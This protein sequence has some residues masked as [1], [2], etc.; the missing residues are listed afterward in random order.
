VWCIL[1]VSVGANSFDNTVTAVHYLHALKEFL[2]FLQGMDVIS[3]ETFFST[4]QGSATHCN[5]F[6]CVFS[7][8][9]DDSV[10]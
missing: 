4:I 3:G 7:E 8:H 1:S 6:L 9:F 2:P 10:V 5:A